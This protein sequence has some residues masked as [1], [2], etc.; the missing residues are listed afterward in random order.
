MNEMIILDSICYN[1]KD[2]SV[3]YF[4]SVIGELDNVIYMNIYYVVFK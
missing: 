4:Y 2:N 1:E 3:S